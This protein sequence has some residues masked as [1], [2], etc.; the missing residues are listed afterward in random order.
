MGPKMH[1]VILVCL[2]AAG[3]AVAQPSRETPVC[4]VCGEKIS[5]DYFETH[6]R[7][8][9]P[10]CFRCSQ[11]GMPITGAYVTYRDKNYHPDCFEKHVALKCD[12]CGGVIKGRYLVNFWGNAYHPEHKGKILQCDFCNRL[13]VGPLVQGAVRLPDGRHLCGLCRPSAV[14]TL[15][16]A[17]RLL[18]DVA[19]QLKN[20][21]LE[22]DPGQIELCLIGQDSL[23][24]LSLGRSG[25]TKGFTDYTVKKNLFGRVRSESIKVYLLYGMPEVQMKS[26]IAHELCH[27]WQFNRGCLDQDH[28]LAEGS[29]N[30][31][32]YLVLRRDGS[33]EAEFI[34][35]NMMHDD[36][37]AYGEGFRKVKKYVE[38][39]GLGKW[40][41]LLEKRQK[42]PP[43]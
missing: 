33:Q 43:L 22:V 5:G 30:F 38:E 7:F 28:V 8:Y 3:S 42:R 27:V 18:A 17:R 15:D 41:R 11:C 12:V 40:R 34:I 13:I 1:L 29:A 36:D 26:T 20:Y 10:G 16:A 39:N 35:D 25:D 14:T 24:E 23:R 6:G 19:G 37:P 9:H 31:V 21:G 2:L 4:A 32:S